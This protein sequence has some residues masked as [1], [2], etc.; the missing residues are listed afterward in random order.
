MEKCYNSCMTLLEVHSL[1]TPQPRRFTREE[2]YQMADLGFFQDHRVELIEGEIIEMAPQKNPH[3][4]A[5]SLAA[6]ALAK[7]FGGS[8][9]IRTQ[10]PLHLEVSE[11]EPDLAVVPGPM[12]SYS[13]HPSTALLIV[14]VADA[15]LR[16]DRGRKASMY[17]RAGIQDYWIINIS[18]HCVEVHRDPVADVAAHLGWRYGSIVTIHPPAVISP[19]AKPEAGVAVGELLP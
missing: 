13:D 16:F 17:A 11:P 15:T 19:L 12:E 10:A 8:Y 5:T 14:E 2:Y 9:W 6:R 3:V 7:A 1:E 4:L 18:E